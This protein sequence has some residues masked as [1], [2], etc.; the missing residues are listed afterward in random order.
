MES[1]PFMAPNDDYESLKALVLVLSKAAIGVYGALAATLLTASAKASAP[2]WLVT[3]GSYLALGIASGALAP[4]LL[5]L[6]VSLHQRQP[7][8]PPNSQSLPIRWGTGPR[9]PQQDLAAFIESLPFS[10]TFMTPRVEFEEP[11]GP[12]EHHVY[13]AH[14]DALGKAHVGMGGIDGGFD[15]VARDVPVVDKQGRK[16]PF[17]VVRSEHAICSPN[18]SGRVHL[19]FPDHGPRGSLQK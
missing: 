10:N 15:Y 19:H 12:R 6:F 13:V 16:T 4:S 11:A 17:A 18:A 9:D 5:W 8:D 3:S 2:D 14:P 7:A 1:G